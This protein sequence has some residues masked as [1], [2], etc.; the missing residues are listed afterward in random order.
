MSKIVQTTGPVPTI[1]APLRTYPHRLP[2]LPSDLM[3]KIFSFLG[4][5]DTANAAWTHSYFRAE[6][7]E[8][9]RW[10]LLFRTEFSY[11][12]LECYRAAMKVEKVSGLFAM[13]GQDRDISLTFRDSPIGDKEFQDIIKNSPPLKEIRLIGCPNLTDESIEILGKEKPHLKSIWIETCIGL[14]NRTL[15]FYLFPELRSIGFSGEE[16]FSKDVREF[17]QNC[18]LLTKFVMDNNGFT[19]TSHLPTRIFRGCPLLEEVHFSQS[20][21]VRSVSDLIPNLKVIKIL[22]YKYTWFVEWDKFSSYREFDNA[23]INVCP[24]LIKTYPNIII[25]NKELYSTTNIE[26]DELVS[27]VKHFPNLE[28]IHLPKKDTISDKALTKIAQSCPHLSKVIFSAKY[29]INYRHMFIFAKYC[30][31]FQDTALHPDFASQGTTRLG[32]LYKFLIDNAENNY[33]RLTCYRTVIQRYFLGLL[34]CQQ[35]QVYNTLFPDSPL[36]LSTC[37]QHNLL[38]KV[39]G[40][41]TQLSDAMFPFLSRDNIVQLIQIFSTEDEWKKIS[42]GPRYAVHSLDMIC[43]AGTKAF[44]IEELDFSTWTSGSNEN[45]LITIFKNGKNLRSVDISHTNI[46][47]NAIFHLAKLPKLKKA[48]FKECVG[49]TDES[50]VAL[51]QGCPNLEEVDLMGC[52]K[53]TERSIVALADGCRRLQKLKA[54][55]WK[56]CTANAALALAFSPHGM[57]TNN[58]NKEM[59]QLI[60]R[61]RQEMEMG[62]KTLLGNYYLNL[63]KKRDIKAIAKLEF[64]FLLP[65]F[66]FSSAD[67]K[68][69]SE[70]FVAF[71]E[72]VSPLIESGKYPP[73]PEDMGI[74]MK[75]SRKS[76]AQP[77]IRFTYLNENVLYDFSDNPQ[78][79]PEEIIEKIKEKPDLKKITLS[80]CVKVNDEV[81]DA[82]IQ[83]CP[84]L[85]D[86][87]FEDC[88][89]ISNEAVIK[90]A[91]SKLDLQQ[92]TLKNCTLITGSGIAALNINKTGIKIIK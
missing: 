47:D 54:S 39:I 88:Y 82:I 10:Q 50:I 64:Q 77:P 11:A 19:D 87:D 55:M 7:S 53:L 29:S 61:Y 58:D 22:K 3:S 62:P 52:T 18:P 20:I 44:Q 81:V 27:L 48:V 17:Q 91:Q 35:L 78:I 90:L 26:D 60:F 36:T 16:G 79:S 68:D 40:D 70:N 57:S 66:P 37:L 84:N 9:L 33:G 67:Y 49:L 80:G 71:C 23:L 63:L 4:P 56:T 2:F 21:N 8:G 28:I 5:K 43:E 74:V 32:L 76:E 34:P 75:V 45:D 42:I 38:K 89:D 46:T 65:K 59:D 41:H 69:M 85:T 14:K 51:S 13:M 83:L 73:L 86:I 25:L 72:K 12:D 15:Y 24:E 6:A 30:P 92:I 1:N 31:K